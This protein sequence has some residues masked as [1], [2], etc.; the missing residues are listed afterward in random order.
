[1]A[2]NKETRTVDVIL[3]GN[4]PAKTLKELNQDI[5][6]LTSS[7]RQLEINSP[8]WDVQARRLNELRASFRQANSDISA[9]G[10]SMDFFK[11]QL[12]ATAVG[13]IGGNLITS[14]MQSITGYFSGA[15]DGMAKMSDELA[16]I[17]KV[18]M[19]SAEAVDEINSALSKMDTRTSRSE[20]RELAWQA[21]K[22]GN[23][24]KEDVLA[25]VSAA[26][27]IKVA[28]GKDLGSDAITQIGK[29]TDI[30]KLKEE[31]GLE[32]GMLKIASAVNAI[33]MAS[34]ANEKYLVEFTKRMSGIA[35]IAKISAPEVIGLAGT[36]DSLGQTAEVSSTAMSKLMAKMG[37]DVAKFARMAGMKVED[38]RKVMDKS[39]LEALLLVI[40]QMGKSAG[41]LETLAEQLGDIGLDGGRVVGVLGTLSKNM[42]EVRRQTAIATT[43]FEKGTSVV[44]EFNIKNETA[45]AKIEKLGKKINS[46]KESKAVRS[47]I[48]SLIDG[49][50]SLVNFL[51]DSSQYWQQF[52]MI[53][54]GLTIATLAYNA[55][56]IKNIAVK[57]ISLALDKAQ[58]ILV[59]IIT[60]GLRAMIF[61][62][63]ML[64]SAIARKAAAQKLW[65]ATLAINPYTAAAAAIAGLTLAIVNY[66][67]SVKKAREET[68][69]LTNDNIKALQDWA[70][71]RQGEF[72]KMAGDANN[73]E[74]FM[75][76]VKKAEEARAFNFKRVEFWDQKISDLEAKRAKLSEK[77]FSDTDAGRKRELQN[78]QEIKEIDKQIKIEKD[79]KTKLEGIYQTS[80]NTITKLEELRTQKLEEETNAR[81]ELTEEE[82]KRLKDLQA[83][84]EKLMQELMKA[85]RRAMV[86]TIEDEFQR[87][88]AQIQLNNQEK[89]EEINAQI[90]KELS[91][92]RELGKGKTEIAKIY[93]LKESLEA[94]QAAEKG[95][96][97]SAATLKFEKDLTE[98]EYQEEL[99][100]LAQRQAGK[101]LLL[102][103][104][105]RDGILTRSEYNDKVAELEVNG[106]M[107]LIDI[108]KDYAKDATDA[109]LQLSSMLISIMEDRV[110]RMQALNMAEAEQRMMFANLRV[111]EASQRGTGMRDALREQFDAAN[112]LLLLQLANE[113]ELTELTE[114]QKLEIKK[115]YAA[116]FAQLQAE[117]DQAEMS[118]KIQIA[119]TT[120]DVLSSFA[121][122]L[123]GLR[124]SN[125]RQET[126]ELE[127]KQQQDLKRLDD[128]R[129]REELT[130]GE[131]NKRKELME[132]Q[133]NKKKLQ[134]KQKEARAEK[135]AALFSI[136]MDTARN[137]VQ[138][139]PNL[140]LMAAAGLLGAVQTGIVA[141]RK[142]PQFK[143]GTKFRDRILDGPSHSSSYGGID[144][145]DPRTGRLVGKA[146]GGEALLSRNTVANNPEIVSALLNSSMNRN[147]APV[148]QLNYGAMTEKVRENSF[149]RG[150][151][152]YGDLMGA[153]TGRNPSMGEAVDIPPRPAPPKPKEEVK[154]MERLAD[155]LERIER[156]GV[157]GY[158]DFERHKRSMEK[159]ERAFARGNVG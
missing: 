109:E 17:R 27:K 44:D 95:R 135:A 12:K 96:A 136:A 78:L 15:V 39:G 56:L 99:K 3:N 154:V 4:Q 73:D 156:D 103:Q 49:L 133:F 77:T 28:L 24:S 70:N 143:K 94:G 54:A 1:M 14:A 50:D 134:L 142:V 30:F 67:K 68:E 69:K 159:A 122:E 71:K 105:L 125:I 104:E 6:T 152:M 92:A 126:A 65:N 150:A 85:S 115:R 149:A 131:Y 139:F 18:T 38:F 101:R 83:E 120:L 93:A 98:T 52:K 45:A 148:P 22:L 74:D 147:G 60:A 90:A 124:L 79:R 117:Y 57:R 62:E 35:G 112:E 123:F 114:E 140:A 41:G 19:L 11:N 40:E 132:E 144:M 87:E 155:V 110:Q 59:N 86:Q 138:V 129:S 82:L 88:L 32:Q 5:R 61:V 21:G 53:L 47:A 89:L 25:F 31:Y 43:E 145:I 76:V 127:Q 75:A 84:Y 63:E 7:M 157:E 81:K 46:L 91:L 36:L 130:E 8:E 13:V 116:E 26:D 151:L 141:S 33:G 111:N 128:Q 137:I 72:V 108:L 97:I 29:L 42:D 48:Q 80:V 16:D 23:Q 10:K 118:R 64:T 146:E 37:G 158:W 119:Q 106:K 58:G 100:Q 113:L 107:V 20:L 34:T 121:N 51:R 9:T 66:S 2:R 153:R 102:D 55:V